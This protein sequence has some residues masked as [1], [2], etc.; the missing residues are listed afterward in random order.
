M[1]DSFNSILTVQAQNRSSLLVVDQDSM[2]NHTLLSEADNSIPPQPGNYLKVNHPRLHTKLKASLLKLGFL[3]R[4]RVLKRP[5]QTLRVKSSK[6][7]PPATFIKAAS[8][9]ETELLKSAIKQQQ[10]EVYR[11]K[12]EIAQSDP[13]C[14]S[15]PSVREGRNLQR[16]L[17]RKFI[18]LSKQDVDLWA[19]WPSKLLSKVAHVGGC[20][21]NSAGAT[22]SSNKSTRNA[23]KKRRRV[24]NRL[25]K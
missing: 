7:I 4:C 17:D 8:A 6:L 5:P 12:Q 2:P 13:S 23:N 18:W 15:E 24:D 14:L 22:N 25:K 3:K 10:E 16:A 21:G 9:A 19:A 11:I 1:D 20:F